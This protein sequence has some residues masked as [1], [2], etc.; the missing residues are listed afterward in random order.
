MIES[1]EFCGASR[2]GDELTF[3]LGELEVASEDVDCVSV[4]MN[5]AVVEQQDDSFFHFALSR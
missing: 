5:S 4:L 3:I 1:V 2:N